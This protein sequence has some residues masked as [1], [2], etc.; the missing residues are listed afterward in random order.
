MGITSA[1]SIKYVGPRIQRQFCG[2][3]L[4]YNGKYS[5]GNAF[6]IA[7]NKSELMGF[8]FYGN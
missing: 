8:K 4:A 2:V 3:Y 7:D 6:L 5:N 1:I